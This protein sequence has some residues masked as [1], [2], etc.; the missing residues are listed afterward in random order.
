VKALSF[1]ISENYFRS[2]PTFDGVTRAPACWTNVC[3]R[4]SA[5]FRLDLPF[6]LGI[7]STVGRSRSGDSSPSWDYLPSY[8]VDILPH[9]FALA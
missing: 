9:A 8:G 3:S 2:I 4:S 1:D 6:N 7:Y 5:G